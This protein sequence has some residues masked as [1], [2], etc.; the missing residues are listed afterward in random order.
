MVDKNSVLDLGGRRCGLRCRAKTARRHRLRRRGHCHWPG[1]R[2]TWQGEWQGLDATDQGVDLDAT[3]HGVAVLTYT[4]CP[5]VPRLSPAGACVLS[6]A[7]AAAPSSPSSRPVTAVIASRP[8]RS[9]APNRPRAPGLPRAPE[10]PIRHRRPRRA[11]TSPP[12]SPPPSAAAHLAGGHGPLAPSGLH[13]SA[14]AAGNSVSFLE[15]LVIIVYII[16]ELVIYLE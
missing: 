8:R 16:I 9:R 3:D 7:S 1:R 4:P 11:P 2:V 6:Q 5:V 15:K 13:S 10:T 14:A 12:P